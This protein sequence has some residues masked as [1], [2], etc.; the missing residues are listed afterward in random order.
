MMIS[1]HKTII[2]YVV[3]KGS[4]SQRMKISA[5]WSLMYHMR[6]IKK[7]NLPSCM[8]DVLEV[9]Y[10]YN[11]YF[12]GNLYMN[13]RIFEYSK[14]IYIQYSLDYCLHYICSLDRHTYSGHDQL[15]KEK[16]IH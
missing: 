14:T 4:G 9:S 3:T 11:I 1:G 12:I 6:K 2:I 10:I 13:M 8:K 5:H 16:Y 7:N 15:G